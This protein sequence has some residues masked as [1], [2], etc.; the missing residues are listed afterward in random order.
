MKSVNIV[1]QVIYK[2]FWH[3]MLC[4]VVNF[5]ETLSFTGITLC[6]ATNHR[7]NY[8]AFESHLCFTSYLIPLYAPF[9]NATD[10][11]NTE[12]QIMIFHY[13]R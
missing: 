7:D 9:E 5:E 13:S 2:D 3:R 1:L 11:S 6:A 12:M 8:M 10:L 4:S